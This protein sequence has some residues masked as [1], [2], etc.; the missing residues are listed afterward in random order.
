MAAKYRPFQKHLHDILDTQN[1]RNIHIHAD[2]GNT[3]KNTFVDTE[4]L[5]ADTL[6]IQSAETK[7]IA[8]AW[9]PKRHKRIIIDVPKGKMQYLNTSAIEKLKN[10]TIFSTMHTP[11]MKSS[12]FKPAIVI[13]GNENCEN[14]WTEDRLTC[15]TTTVGDFSFIEQDWQTLTETVGLG[16]T[17]Q[18]YSFI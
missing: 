18:Q 14:A 10:G 13:L 8:Y 17:E 16:T 6:V 3:G 4:N 2:L 9:N 1:D 5:R 7:R 12:E 15:S 11:I